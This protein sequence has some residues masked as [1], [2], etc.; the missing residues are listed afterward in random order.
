VNRERLAQWIE[1]AE[2]PM[3]LAAG[4]AVAIYL[5]ELWGVWQSMGLQMPYLALAIFID[6]LFVADL[7]AKVVALR[8]AYLRTPWALIDL[9]CTLPV[10]ASLSLI[11]G[12]MNALRFARALRLLRALRMLRVL[13]TLRILRLISDEVNTEETRAWHRALAAGVLAYSVG[14]VA[15]VHEA[16]REAE[17]GTLTPDRVELLLVLGA[18][19]GLALLML[20]ARYQVPAVFSR[21]L[22]ALLNVALPEQVASWLLAN[23]ERYDHT[24]RAPASVIF[25]DIKGFTATA[26]HLE[27]DVLKHHLERALDVVVEAHLA[28]GL[29]IDKFIGDAVMSFRGGEI[30]GGE[31]EDIAWSS[32][33]AALDGV[34]AL[35]ELQDPW[36][37]TVKVGG[38]SANNALIGAFGTQR[39]LSYTI[40]GDKVNLAARLEAACNSL[41]VATLFC[42]QTHRLTAD[43]ED[44]VWRR[45]GRVR[46]QGRVE[47]AMAWE[48]FDPGDPVAWIE[49]YHQ[50]VDALEAG[51]FS[52]ARQGFTQVQE[53]READGPTAHYLS[54]LDAWER[55]ERRESWVPVL[56]T[57]K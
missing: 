9:L 20:V 26:E 42:D 33:R 47:A 1:R 2:G 27:L 44:I 45:V 23:P 21:Q 6:L 8:G 50:A 51:D 48:A 14:F 29:I 35:R 55:E 25:C 17:M 3:L 10:L 13:R 54:R 39:R 53:L 46:V 41:G 40:L 7:V 12:V 19:M 52:A 34:L 28:R 38:A 32:V 15:L 43:R 16:R 24:V 56:E 11:P 18:I 37:T 49:V 36:F 57:R 30:V 4:V 31:P 22:R 5:L